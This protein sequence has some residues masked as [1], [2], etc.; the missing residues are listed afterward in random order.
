MI[1]LDFSAHFSYTVVT[2]KKPTLKEVY[3]SKIYIR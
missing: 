2:M 3:V 1:S